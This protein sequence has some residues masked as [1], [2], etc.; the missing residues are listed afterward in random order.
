[1]ISYERALSGDYH[2]DNWLI[3]TIEVSA[4]GFSGSAKATIQAA[5]LVSFSEQLHSFYDTLSGTAEFSTLEDQLHL[6]FTGN[7]KGGIRLE[8]TVSDAPGIGN[9]LSFSFEFDQTYLQRSL[10][11]LEAV[12]HAFPVRTIS[13]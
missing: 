1:V 3:V 10:R 9:T 13:A 8:G 11:E 12:L 6:T 7:R 4:G 5:E 2:D